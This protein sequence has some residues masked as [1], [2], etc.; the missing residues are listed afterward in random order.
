MTDT[1]KQS[2]E[3]AFHVISGLDEAGAQQARQDLEKAVISHGGVILFSKDPERIRLAYPINHQTSSYFGFFNFSLEDKEVINAIRDDLKVNTN[4]L[5]SLILKIAP[6]SKREKEG[7]V[8]RLANAEKRRMR[9]AKQA[10][11]PSSKE[12][13]SKLDEKEIDDKLEEIIDKL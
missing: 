1:D 11:K 4:I 7:V 8:R 13:P 10:E 9:T 6:E 12:E 5:R 3:L 2:Y